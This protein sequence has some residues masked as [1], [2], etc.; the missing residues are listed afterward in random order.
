MSAELH[1]LIDA[2]GG[3]CCVVRGDG[4]IEAASPGFLALTGA[5]QQLAG[6]APSAVF[7]ELPALDRLG[8]AVNE[9]SP[10]FRHVGADGVGRELAAAYVLNTGGVAGGVLVLVDRS[11]EAR[12]RRGQVRL[13]REI[14]DLEAQLAERQRQPQRSRIRSMPELIG[15]LEEA[16]MRSRRYKH[17]VSC[18]SLQIEMPIDLEHHEDLAKRIGETLVGCVRGVDELGSASVRRESSPELSTA[19]RWVFVLPHTPL[20]GGE[21]VATRVLTRL[22]GIDLARVGLGVAQVGAEEAGSAAV[23]R[24]DQASAQALESGGGVLLAVALI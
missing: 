24:A 20:A 16:V 9:Q 14:D 23:E 5:P 2:T 12:L 10:V 17:D 4:T 21:I 13:S 7:A 19:H 18:I 22:A 8:A 3:G 6:Q 1:R 11:G 15:R